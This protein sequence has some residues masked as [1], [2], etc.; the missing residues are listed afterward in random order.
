MLGFAFAFDEL[1][2]LPLLFELE[3]LGV[4]VFPSLPLTPAVPPLLP[5][6]LATQAVF[7]GFSLYPRLHSN[8]LDVHVALAGHSIFPVR[9]KLLNSPPGQ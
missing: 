1:K 8:V 2:L 4:E 9:V 3:L 7:D 5:P 6:P